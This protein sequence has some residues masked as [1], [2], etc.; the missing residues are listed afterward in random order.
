MR[1]IRGG[2]TVGWGANQGHPEVRRIPDVPQAGPAASRARP[3]GGRLCV[4]A[5]CPH[6]RPAACLPLGSVVG[7]RADV[8]QQALAAAGLI[9]VCNGRCVCLWCVFVCA[10]VRGVRCS[11][12]CGASD[13]SM[14]SLKGRTAWQRS[15]CG[16]AQRKEGL[17]S[18]PH[19]TC[20]APPASA[21][22]RATPHSGSWG[23]RQQPQGL[24]R[25]PQTQAAPIGLGSMRGGTQAGAA[26]THP[27][28]RT[29]RPAQ[30][31]AS[32][33]L[34]ARPPPS[35][36]PPT[37]RLRCR[38][39]WQRRRG[40]R[41]RPPPRRAASPPTASSAPSAVQQGA[42]RSVSRAALWRL[43]AALPDRTAQPTCS[44]LFSPPGK[45]S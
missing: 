5:G 18:R 34:P 28:L 7:H 17:R 45:S 13:G 23:L 31:A 37:G 9:H 1:G 27:G 3:G 14:S 35:S 19:R 8:G 10:W 43:V 16:A 41:R 26:G 30:P 15:R 40:R 36:V 38:A 33:W 39:A 12:D 42:Y 29:S 2:R 44:R 25:L 22:R 11:S 4:R 24:P 20:P 32:P 6:C 21:L